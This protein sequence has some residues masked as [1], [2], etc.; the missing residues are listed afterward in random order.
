MN[1]YMIYGNAIGQA[2]LFA[3]NGKEWDLNKLT[4]PQ[5]WIVGQEFPKIVK[6][7]FASRAKKKRI[8]RAMAIDRAKE[9]FNRLIST[10]GVGKGIALGA[11][12]DSIVVGS[13]TAFEALAEDLWVDVL[14]ARPRLGLIALDAEIR[15]SD[16]QTTKD[17]KEKIII[18]LPAWR[19]NDPKY[20]IQKRMGDLLRTYKRDF[21]KRGQAIS[22][23]Q[24]VFPESRAALTSIFEFKKLKWA[25]ATR[26]A[27]IHSGGLADDEFR[28]LVRDHPKLKQIK[29]DSPI[30]LN[31]TIAYELSIAAIKAGVA[32]LD[33]AN[34]WM[35]NNLT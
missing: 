5:K 6:Q 24:K 3:T 11:I 19:L 22:S 35:K 2:A 18:P 23:Y 9:A 27:I 8:E 10:S 13:W 12:M 25:S 7:A 15:E 16:K 34:G 30:V 1:D 17:E 29:K 4:D 20:K 14:N 32:L 26:N 31:G 21:S 28:K 33:F